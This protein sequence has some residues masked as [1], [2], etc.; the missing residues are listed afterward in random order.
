MTIRGTNQE[1]SQVYNRSL[2][3]RT[4]QHLR[5]CSRVELAKKTGLKQATISHIINDFIENKIVEET[6][7][8]SG[9]K[10]RRAIGVQLSSENFR[11]IGFRL[12][13]QYYTIGA[14]T[15]N[16]TEVGERVHQDISNTDPELII[17]E[18]CN[19]INRIIADNPDQCFLAVGVAVPGPYY[20]DTGVI[21]M[22]STFPGWVDV[23]IRERMQARINIPII[24]D[25]DANAGAMAE[26]SL[27]DGRDMYNSMVYVSA[28]Q[29]IGAG[30]VY[31]GE[32][33][34]G[35]FGVAGEIG[36]TCIEVNGIQC[37]CGRR[38]C[39]TQY[40]STIA[41]RKNIARRLGSGAISYAEAVELILRGDPLAVDE[42]RNMMK[43]MGVGMVNLL[44]TYNPSCIV[45]GDELSEIGEPVLTELRKQLTGIGVSR[46]A[47]Q[48]KLELAQLGFDSAY[49]GAA[50][51]ATRYVF[52]HIADFI[53][54][55]ELESEY[56]I[57]DV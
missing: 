16:C 9:S 44:Y 37:D 23:R 46:V 6:G 21:A 54:K 56:E 24:V 30:I 51:I 45:I 52:D 34:G 33:Y 20:S 29:G 55:E 4:L 2:V 35:S 57:L 36:H 1:S 47:T 25:H 13:R 38:G 8:L 53:E 28:G 32:V 3:L 26:S 22:I 43:Y 27:V 50:T 19:R 48:V 40:A 12:T 31:N 7:S 11:V 10:G 49:I 42:F 18:V 17:D 5:H 39:L 41:L 14:F 15:L